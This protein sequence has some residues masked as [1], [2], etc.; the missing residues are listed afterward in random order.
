MLTSCTFIKGKKN[1][2][3]EITP[4]HLQDSEIFGKEKSRRISCVP[5][6]SF[7]KGSYKVLFEATA[8]GVETISYLDKVFVGEE[9][10]DSA[11]ENS[12][13]LR[14][15]E[16]QQKEG[17]KAGEE[18]AVFYFEIGTAETIV[19]AKDEPVLPLTGDVKNLKKGVVVNVN[20]V[21]VN[22]RGLDVFDCPFGGA[23]GLITWEGTGLPSL[24]CQV[25]VPDEIR[26]VPVL[27]LFPHKYRAVMN[28]DYKIKK[29]DNFKIT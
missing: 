19:F 22:L 29:E 25:N 13:I 18:F 5:S 17:S 4:E 27:E 16:L 11:D 24:N 28:Y 6:Q 20:K 12:K 10:W 7:S 2:S 14:F 26:D 9:I 23:G 3:G 1:F 8:F 15:L 21:Q